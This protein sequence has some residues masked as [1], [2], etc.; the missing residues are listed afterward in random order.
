M[1]QANITFSAKVAKCFRADTIIVLIK[2]GMGA[3]A[4]VQGVQ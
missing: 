2:L 3:S 4:S 1:L